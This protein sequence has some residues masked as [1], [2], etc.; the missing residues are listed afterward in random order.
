MIKQD[1]D[2]DNK[3]GCHLGDFGGVAYFCQRTVPVC[4]WN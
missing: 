3:I 1:I 4:T 2:K